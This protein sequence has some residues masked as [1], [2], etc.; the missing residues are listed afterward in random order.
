MKIEFPLNTRFVLWHMHNRMLDGQIVLVWQS[1]PDYQFSFCDQSVLRLPPGKD[2]RC[3]GEL[4]WEVE[5]DHFVHHLLPLQNRSEQELKE[6][7][8]KS[9]A[10]RAYREKLWRGYSIEER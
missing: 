1:G 7:A 2:W 8:L 3:I 9:E 10:H 5:D 6:R 4:V